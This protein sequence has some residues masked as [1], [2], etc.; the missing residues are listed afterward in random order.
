[1]ANETK[2][3][4]VYDYF[5]DIADIL[6]IQETHS[7]ESDYKVWKNQWGGEIIL[8]HGESN[9]RG[10][11]IFIKIST[12]IIAS[13]IE[14]SDDGRYIIL[15]IEENGV[16]TSCAAIYAPNKDTPEFFRQIAEK[17]ITRNENKIIIGDFNVVLD[18]EKDRLNTYANNEKSKQELINMMDEYSRKEIWRERNPGTSIYSW[19]KGN[20][21]NE[22]KASRI[23]Y[24]LVSMGLDQ[25]VENC[26]YKS[27]ILSDH[28]AFFIALDVN[29]VERGTGFWKMN[30][31][32]LTDP[33][34]VEKI[35]IEIDRIVSCSK[36][37]TRIWTWEKIKERV[38]KVTQEYARQKGSEEKLIIAQ[39]SEK[40]NLLEDKIPLTTEEQKNLENTK[41]DLE[42]KIEERIQGVIFRS[43]ARWYE[44]GE[45][46]SKYFFALEKAKYNA[47]TCYRIIDDEGNITENQKEIIEQQRQFYEELYSRDENVEFNLTNET[48][49]RVP[50]KIRKEQQIQLTMTDLQN[51]AKSLKNNKTPGE[52]GIP[53]DFYK[54]FWNRI[55]EPFFQM[56]MEVYQQ[57]LLHKS[58][59][60]GILN[61]IP[62]PNKD[63]RY[64]KNLRPITLLNTDYKIIE[65]A[66]ANKMIPALKNIIQSDQRGFMKE[67]RIS[68]N[69]RKLLDLME[70][71]KENDIEALILSLDFVKCFDKCSFS[72]LHGSLEFFQFGDIIQQWTKI[73]YKDF[74]VKVQN[75]G[76]FSENI[77]IKKG[78]HQG[79][80]CSS[81]YFLVIAEILAMA[82]RGNQKIKGITVGQIKN[83][84]NQ[85]ADDADIASINSQESL[86][87]I[88]EELERFKKQSGFTLSYEKTVLYRIGSLRHSNAMLYNM[89][90]VEWSNEDINVLGVTVAHED[91]LEKNYLQI[92]TKVQN[93]LNHWENRG[94]TLMGK[95]LVVNTLIASLFVYKMMVLPT[96]P[97]SIIKKVENEIRKYLWE[98]SSSKISYQILKNPPELGGLKLVDLKN[99][100]K[101]LKATWPQILN[102]ETQYAEMVYFQNNIKLKENIWRANLSPKHSKVLQIKNTF[103]ED[104]I[105]AWCEFNHTETEITDNQILWYNSEILVQNQPFLWETPYN[106]GLMYVHQLYHNGVMIS[107]EQLKQLYGITTLQYNTLTVSIPKTHKQ[108]YSKLTT[109]SFQPLTPSK[110]DLFKEE[111]NLSKIIYR[112]INGDKYIIQNKLVKWNQELGINWSIEDYGRHHTNIRKYTNYTK[113]RDFQYRLLQ[114]AIVTNIQLKKWGIIESELCTFCNEQPET[115]IHLLVHCTKVKTMWDHF[116]EYS[117]RKY[118]KYVELTEEK[119][120]TN[121]FCKPRNHVVNFIGLLL[122]QYIYSKRCMKSDLK[123]EFFLQHLYKIKN[124]EKY[125]ALKN[126]NDKV[127]QKKWEKTSIANEKVSIENFIMEYNCQM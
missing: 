31:L 119:I 83:L 98:G 50:E 12:K 77:E 3:K 89:N 123:F 47:K 117:S 72:I 80:C 110:Y 75:N 1:M 103:W 16:Q 18:V 59:R 84:L 76:H 78:V 49:I 116:K 43:K 90:Q 115:I 2:R 97:Q 124:I 73:L 32:H 112:N 57:E 93:T 113:I 55:K 28:R 70:H 42:L 106:N 40:V 69:I 122:K 82:L 58:A 36:S 48:N 29:H 54:V 4:K 107:R 81:V 13:N 6:I 74:S 5:R 65:K 15:D 21:N 38:K 22:Q 92:H 111:R 105:K 120:I 79:G 46:S 41:L 52:D 63:T 102:K 10:I 23:D 33:T 27:G 14:K 24:A 8:S 71:T 7:Q 66:I 30:T 53:V 101:A 20:Q 56:V 91:L 85:F 68:V 95:V 104:V 108:F 121:V 60:S 100:D 86:K 11:A 118:A 44:H 45:K 125:I 26:M 34:Y 67:R 61:L 25:K 126:A 94:L 64:V 114:R 88:F 96:M 127:Y 39:L 87:A 19:I 51:A 17:L 62:K 109:T 35:N 99:K 9:S 37:K